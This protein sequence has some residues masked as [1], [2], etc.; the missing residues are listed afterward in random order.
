MELINNLLKP[1]IMNLDTIFS[2]L[3]N[4][5]SLQ[6]PSAGKIHKLF[7]S[8]GETIINDHIAF[9]TFN[10]PDIS[11]DV[12]AKVFTDRGYKPAGEYHFTEKKLYARH[13]ELPGDP[14]AP[15]IFISE[16]LLE[17]FSEYL[18]SLVNNAVKSIPKDL[19]NPEELIFAGDAFGKISWED[20]E[21]LRS[22]SEY[23]AWLYAFGFRAN[24]FTVSINHLKTLKGIEEVNSLLKKEGFQLNS[25]G[26]EIKGS[27][28]E[29]LCQSSTL[30]D[31]VS[32]IFNDGARSIPACY[33]EFA[34]RFSDKTG[35]LFSGFIAGSADKIF[36]STDF[37]K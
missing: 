20:Y 9:R 31:K 27:P 34:E 10:H 29:L 21:I 23:A 18:Q 22:E 30:A 28:A 14:L 8:R 37:R 16:L 24:H 36:E 15:R 6:N 25:S 26:G 3:W 12:L 5:Y 35:K 7:E 13:Y 2:Q 4:D 33:Y 19:L 32:Y 1:K 11:I 17:N